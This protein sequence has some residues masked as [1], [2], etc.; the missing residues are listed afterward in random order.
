MGRDGI[1]IDHMVPMKKINTRVL[2]ILWEFGAHI[3]G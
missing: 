3:D 2:N 1:K